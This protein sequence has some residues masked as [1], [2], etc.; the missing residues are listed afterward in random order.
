VLRGVLEDGGGGRALDQIER[1]AD[2]IAGDVGSD[3]LEVF[4][5]RCLL[6]PEPP[7]MPTSGAVAA[8]DSFIAW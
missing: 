5:A 2:A 6:C 1:D 7:A 3:R 8:T 4:A